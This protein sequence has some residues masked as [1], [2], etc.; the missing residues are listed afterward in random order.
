MEILDLGIK[1]YTDTLEIQKEILQKRI[2]GKIRD[3][4]IIVEHLPVVTT[5]RLKGVESIIDPGYFKEKNIP[6]IAANRGGGVT[7]HCPGQLVLYPVIDLSYLEKNIS[8]FIDFLEK[9]IANSLKLLDLPVERINGK[10]GVWLDRKKIAFTG[11]AF[12]KWVS[13]HGVSI[14]INND[15]FP[16]SK[17]YPCG[18]KDIEAISMKEY[19]GCEK[20]MFEVKEVFARQFRLDLNKRYRKTLL[21]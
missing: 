15:I 8:S 2:S 18:V 19:T 13:Y 1:E 11:I 5:G 21:V 12:K 9:T 6:V 17:M 20:N 14:N 7:Y 10:R 16:F 4:L 3:T